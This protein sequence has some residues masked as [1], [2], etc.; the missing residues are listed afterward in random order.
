MLVQE[1]ARHRCKCKDEHHKMELNGYLLLEESINLSVEYLHTY[2]MLD[3]CD[4]AG[5]VGVNE[6]IAGPLPSIIGGETCH[7]EEQRKHLTHCK[8]L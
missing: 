4:G 8:F 6:I 2:M 3:E 5:G 7:R 1:S